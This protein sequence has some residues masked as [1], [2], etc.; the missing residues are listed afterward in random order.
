MTTDAYKFEVILGRIIVAAWNSKE[1]LALLQKDP[2][3]I[4]GGH[5]L[6]PPP[7]LQISIHADTASTKHVIA[8]PEWDGHGPG[9]MQKLQREPKATLESIGYTVHEGIEYKVLFNTNNHTNIVIPRKPSH[10]ECSIEK[11]R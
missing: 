5:G 8:R 6:Q 11:I 10:H 3:R 9:F 4:M 1:F 7:G 2:R